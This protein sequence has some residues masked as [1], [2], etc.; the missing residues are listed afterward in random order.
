MR[1][2]RTFAIGCAVLGGTFGLGAYVS[3]HGGDTNRVHACVA[4]NGSLRVVS[5]TATCKP[6]ETTLDWDIIGPQGPIG[7][8]GSQGPAGSTGPQGPI[9]PQGQTGPQGQAGPQGEAGAQGAAGLSGYEIVSTALPLDTSASG[10]DSDAVNQVWHYGT[11][12]CPAGKSVISASHTLRRYDGGRLSLNEWANLVQ[13]G[14]RL[15]ETEGT[16]GYTVYVINPTENLLTAD[17][18]MVCANV[19]H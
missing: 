14:T 5:A 8:T 17:V 3:A 4:T 19:T 16:G 15:S 1:N 11:S 18:T 10:L 2:V 12:S 9:G 13:W 7:L 6:S